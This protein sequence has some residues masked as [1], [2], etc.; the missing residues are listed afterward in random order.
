[1]R[2]SE[3]DAPVYAIE[4]IDAVLPSIWLCTNCGTTHLDTGP[5]VRG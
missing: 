3:I 4:H 5:A 2:S 1:V